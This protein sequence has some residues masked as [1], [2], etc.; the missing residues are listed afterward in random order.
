MPRDADVIG[1]MSDLMTVLVYF[2]YLF[3]YMFLFIW[4]HLVSLVACSILSCSI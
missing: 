3:I 4:L 1:L 2:Q